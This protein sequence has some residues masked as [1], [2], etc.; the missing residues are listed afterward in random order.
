M[1][2]HFFHLPNIIQ[3]IKYLLSVNVSASFIKIYQALAHTV[4]NAHN[5]NDEM[6]IMDHA[7][8]S[9]QKSS[10]V[11]FHK[12]FYFILPQKEHDVVKKYTVHSVVENTPQQ[13]IL[14]HMSRLTKVLKQRANISKKKIVK[15]I[16][17]EN[18][19]KGEHTFQMDK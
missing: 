19:K 6:T 8:L 10:S 5:N 3:F 7:F 14:F 2:D 18:R 16:S 12:L 17:G 1:M 13:T 4:E 9:R 15:A 11:Y